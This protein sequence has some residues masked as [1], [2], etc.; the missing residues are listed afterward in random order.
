MQVAGVDGV[1]CE[2][3]AVDLGKAESLSI[4]T[5]CGWTEGICCGLLGWTDTSHSQAYSAPPGWDAAGRAGSL[6]WPSGQGIMGGQ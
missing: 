1:R 6:G 4:C 3:P 2:L 5:S